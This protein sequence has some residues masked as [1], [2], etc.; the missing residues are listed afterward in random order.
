[1]VVYVTVTVQN[2]GIVFAG[3]LLEC[4][5]TF[6]N[7][8]APFSSSPSTHQQSSTQQQQQQSL[9]H[10][11]SRSFSHVNS[12]TT[13]T[14]FP[15]EASI[16]PGGIPES[17]LASARESYSDLVGLN[18]K[19]LKPNSIAVASNIRASSFDL[20]RHGFVEGDQEEQLQHILRQQ[21]RHSI[22]DV[23]QRSST[24]Q[25]SQ[26]TASDSSSLLGKLATTTW[27]L[28]TGWGASEQDGQ[29]HEE[30]SQRAQQHTSNVERETRVQTTRIALPDSTTTSD[31]NAP[32]PIIPSR[33]E[34]LLLLDA[35]E[36]S[37]KAKR[38]SEH[39]EQFLWGFAQF[40]GFF[41]VDPSLIQSDVFESLKKKVLYR[42]AGIGAGSGWGSGGGGLEIRNSSQQ[43]QQQQ[44]QHN[45]SH[46][47]YSSSSYDTSKSGQ[48]NFRTEKNYPIVTTPP[49][50][51]F[52]DMNLEVGE[53]RSCM[54]FN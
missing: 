25:D 48:L 39:C 54:S 16:Q 32:K 4:S 43:Q 11:R 53:S 44:S 31:N 9:R 36:S 30:E 52:H 34:S 29:H 38:P 35:L 50:I 19:G 2:D 40:S 15:R 45:Q 47:S 49:T 51:L 21:Q 42:V 24:H 6:T 26:N 37:N 23:R 5:I 12:S 17:T 33:S 18:G 20:S 3:D 7:V 10:Q 27:S 28:F 8:G 41:T 14:R 46:S 22:D 1:M 13:S